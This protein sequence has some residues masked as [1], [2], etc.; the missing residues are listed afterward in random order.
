MWSFGHKITEIERSH[1]RVAFTETLP[2]INVWGFGVFS[3]GA[4]A[5]T[6][7]SF[8]GVIASLWF[9]GLALYSSIRS[10]FT[11][12]RNRGELTVQRRIAFW[13]I[14]KVY[15]SESI[16]RIFVITTRKGSGLQMRLKSGRKKTLTASLGSDFTN[17]DAAAM[18]L[19]VFVHTH[20]RK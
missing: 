5:M 1:Q 16:D 17:L 7:W 15:S 20:Y 19:N 3:L 18:A 11:A 2:V 13:Q 10:T 6:I 9:G 14:E 12:D 8:A 4:L